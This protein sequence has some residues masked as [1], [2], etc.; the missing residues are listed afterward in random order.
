GKGKCEKWGAVIY[1]KCNE[2]YSN[3]GCCI[4][5]PA[6]PNCQRL[7]LRKEGQ[8][9]LSCAKEVKIAS[10]PKL[11][12]CEPGQE[13]DAGLCYQNCRAGYYGVGPVCWKKNPWGW[14]D[15]GMGAAKDDET[16]A[17]IT[18][19]QI[20]SVGQLAMSVATLGT[21]MV[22]TKAATATKSTGTF[23]QLKQQYDNL[24]AAY[25]A[26]KRSSTPALQTALQTAENAYSKGSTVLQINTA[27]NTALNIFTEADIARLAA[28]IAQIVDPS[29]VAGT[30]AGFTHEKCSKYFSKEL[31]PEQDAQWVQLNTERSPNKL[32]VA[33]YM[34]YPYNNS[35]TIAP[36]VQPPG[37]KD[38][39]YRNRSWRVDSQGDG[40][41]L[42]KSAIRGPGMCLGNIPGAPDKG[43]EP[44]LRP[45][46]GDSPGQHWKLVQDGNWIRLKTLDRCL[47]V[48]VTGA[49]AAP[50]YQPVLQKCSDTPGGADP[51][52]PMTTTGQHWKID[53]SPYT[54]GGEGWTP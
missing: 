7:G 4:C 49:P 2:G 31:Y 41:V 43:N 47:G 8:V 28:Q 11:G 16:C 6:I 13:R 40:T 42:L 30:I 44:Q 26:A 51:R 46:S 12:N 32:S 25:E 20:S 45:C 35:T 14:V 19:N 36:G 17:S 54:G 10:S 21:S 37:E 27:A 24:V 23:A 33:T 3:F 29:G 1:P 38:I 39:E 50:T 48:F 52:F 22:A 34:P 15:C 53:P 18:I 9:D 5:R